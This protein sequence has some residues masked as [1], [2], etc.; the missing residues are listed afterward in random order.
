MKHVLV[1]LFG[2]LCLLSCATADP[3]A[4]PGQQGGGGHGRRPA[5][6]DVRT[7]TSRA[8]VE[9]VG[10]RAVRRARRRDA[11][12][13]R[14]HSSRAS[15]T[16]QARAARTDW[17]KNFAYPAPRTFTYSEIVTPEAGYV[18]GVDSNGRNAAEPEGEPAG[19]LDVGLPPRHLAAR[20]RARQHRRRCCSPM[21]CNPE[22][23]AAG[24]RHRRRSPRFRYD[25]FIV[26]FD[27]QTG[28]PSRVRTL[29]YDNIW[30]DVTYDLVLS[31]WRE[32]GGVKVAMNRKTEL[33]GRVV[34][35][36]QLHRRAH[37]PGDRRRALRRSRPRCAPTRPS[38]PTRN[39][40]YQ[41]VIRRQFIGTYM[42]S[43]NVSYDTQAARR[44][45]GCRR[46]RPACT[47]SSRRHA[48]QPGRRD[49]RPPDR[50]RRA[51]D[52]RAVGCGWSARR[53]AQFPGKPIRWLVLTHHH[54][55]H[56]GGLRGML[57][58][59]GTLVVGQGAGAHFR[60][61]LAAPMTRN[62]DLPAR[63]LR[64]RRR[65]WKCPRATSCP[66]ARGR[67]VMST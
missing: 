6:A 61:V 34:E 26:A 38:R 13:Q 10:A 11:L 30:G 22:Q 4:E 62:P 37:Q 12:R 39:V 40:P 48:Q 32:V 60:R 9:A 47:R 35:R 58:E 5:L 54:M 7:I 29:D 57:A 41:W 23:G 18:I 42:D 21:Q 14:G 16:S 45:C 27:P 20:R 53:S 51:G 56:A 43:D 67:Q 28:L 1:A 8:T 63:T 46:S 55:D 24:G 31:D 49:E 65:S 50:V 59:G 44:A 25:G 3:R 64:T 19:A 2:A 15:P 36:H 33:N 17:V 52:R 66:T